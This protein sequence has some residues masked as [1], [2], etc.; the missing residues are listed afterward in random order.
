MEQAGLYQ[1][2]IILLK[3]GGFVMPP[4]I[5]VTAILWYALGKRMVSLFRGSPKNL[6]ALIK[7]NE[8]HEGVITNAI[9]RIRS[10]IH[11]NESVIE[12]YILLE[13]IN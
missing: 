6:Q 9:K 11:L 8:H 2:I 3:A 13:K 7:D 1:E 10:I 5:I 12:E 4:L